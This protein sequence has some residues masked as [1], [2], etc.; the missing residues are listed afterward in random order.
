MSTVDA[1]GDFASCRVPFKGDS[2][3]KPATRKKILLSEEKVTQQ[4]EVA[5]FRR[6]MGQ[7]GRFGA[8]LK[9]GT[10]RGADSG[11]SMRTSGLTE[12]DNM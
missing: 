9:K 5:N 4:V 6:I 1:K 12:P 11:K 10:V 7:V 3:V 8:M 2:E